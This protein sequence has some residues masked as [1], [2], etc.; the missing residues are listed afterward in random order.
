MVGIFSSRFFF[1][2]SHIYIQ[3]KIIKRFTIFVSRSLIDLPRSLRQSLEEAGTPEAIEQ[4]RQEQTALQ[5]LRR[6][7]VIS[8]LAR[9]RQLPSGFEL[10]MCDTMQEL[11][12]Q[13]QLYH[14][15]LKY[16]RSLQ[17]ADVNILKD[18][19]MSYASVLD[20]LTADLSSGLHRQVV[21]TGFRFVD[22]L[23]ALE[24]WFMAEEVLLNIIN[25]LKANFAIENWVSQDG[26]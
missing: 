14:L 13:P 19:S 12:S 4:L 18:I 1:F 8:A 21:G 7:E 25:F 16:I 22:L 5:Y 24:M 3:Q 6:L 17:E 2:F 10:C 20:M 9:R 26:R 15:Y 11:L 23:L